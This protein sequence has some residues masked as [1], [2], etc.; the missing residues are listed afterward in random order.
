MKADDGSVGWQWKFDP[1]LWRDFH[2]PDLTAMLGRMRCP[3][4]LIRGARSQLMNEGDFAYTHSLMPPGSPWLE[5][6]DADHHVRIDQPLAFVTALNG[7]L[8]AWPG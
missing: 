7:L 6:P 4:A 3:A 5:I 2:M 1:F 8:A